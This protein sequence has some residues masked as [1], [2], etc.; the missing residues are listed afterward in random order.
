MYFSFDK[1]NRYEIPE[2]VLCNPNFN[3]LA[4]ITPSTAPKMSLRF[5]AISEA[6]FEINSDI[7]TFLLLCA[8]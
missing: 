7:H 3:E 6:S 4:V 8:W 2:M 1:F 5:N